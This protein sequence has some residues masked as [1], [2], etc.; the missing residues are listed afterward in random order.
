[1]AAVTEAEVVRS[2]HYLPFNHEDVLRL[3]PVTKQLHFSNLDVKSLLAQASQALKEQQ[4][5]RA[6]ELYS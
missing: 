4:M 5:D 6:F 1:V 3:F 2:Y